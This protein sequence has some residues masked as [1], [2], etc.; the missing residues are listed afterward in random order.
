MSTFRWFKRNQHRKTLLKD[1]L[2]C[3]SS[4]KQLTN[5]EDLLTIFNLDCKKIITKISGYSFSVSSY[6]IIL[7]KE[8]EKK[9][10]LIC[11]CTKYSND[12][13]NGI[14]IIDV[15]FKES[16][17]YETKINFEEI[18]HF[19]IN[20]ICAL[21]NNKKVNEN[22][23]DYKIYLLAG[24]VDEEYK[25]GIIKLYKIEF[26]KNETN[27][28]FLQNI[29]LDNEIEGYISYICQLKDGRIMVSCSNGNVLFTAPNLD[30]Y[31]EDY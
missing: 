25:R 12:Q 18:E 10:H 11:T 27:I 3:F 22:N 13:K 31:N 2:I 6:R 7:L 29:E 28:E 5:G 30:G 26:Q 17:E 16:E 15:E 24:G 20:C 1:N 19:S 4:N 14:I 9:K 8:N 21:N 23:E